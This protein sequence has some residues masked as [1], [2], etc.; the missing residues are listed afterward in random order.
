MYLLPKIHKGW[1]DVSGRLDVSN[2]GTPTQKAS[3][4][5]DSQFKVV[6]QIGWS[7]IKGSNDFV[8]K[9]RTSE[10]HSP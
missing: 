9:K 1:Y 10:E 6:M 8:K 3:E 5:L 7:Y 4:F 2:C